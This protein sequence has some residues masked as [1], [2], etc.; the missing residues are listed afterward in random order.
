MKTIGKYEI[1][2]LLGRGGMGRVYKVSVP[3]IGKI[4]ALKRLEPHPHLVSL[5]GEAGV[6]DR[7]ITEAATLAGLRHPHVVG[8]HD[9]DTDDAGRPFYLMGY[10]F[11]NLGV[12]MGETYRTE[13]PSRILP[14]DRAVHY[15]RQILSGLA[16]LHHFGII[17]RDIKPFNILL[18]E[19][20][21][22]KICDFGLSKVRGETFDRPESLKVGSPFYAAPEQEADPDDAGPAADLYSVGVTLYRMLTGTLPDDDPVLPSRLNPD[23]DWKWDGFML[24]ATARPPQKRFES[25]RRMRDELDRLMADWEARREEICRIYPVPELPPA[26]GSTRCRDRCIKVRPADAAQSFGTD[27]LLRPLTSVRND[28]EVRRDGTVADRVTGLIWEQSGSEYPLT[29]AGASDYLA[30]LNQ[31]RLA[32]RTDWRLPTVDELSTLLRPVS[33]GEALCID[34]VFDE[35]QKRIWSCDRRSFVAAWFV[36]IDLGFIGWEDRTGHFYV[37]G[38]CSI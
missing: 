31:R 32:D 4:A 33:H 5:L 9:F 28:F 7:F 20:D 34:P 29:F 16:C 35:R 38:V 22:V 36:S 17:H 23:L 25:A 1:R 37:R 30:A 11:N 27:E 19:Y 6:R 14:L 15:T 8:I 13:A 3:V 26:G 21:S 2:G 18:T 10:W 24:R 12:M